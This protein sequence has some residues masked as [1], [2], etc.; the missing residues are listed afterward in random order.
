MSTTLMVGWPI[1]VIDGQVVTA[2]SAKYSIYNK[3]GDK[4]GIAYLDLTN[5]GIAIV[6]PEKT[7]LII[8]RLTL[9]IL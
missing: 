3:N 5:A 8:A 6:H 9:G 7:N 4:V 2:E 1:G